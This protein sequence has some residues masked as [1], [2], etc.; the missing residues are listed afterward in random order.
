[1]IELY[2][3][4][5]CPVCGGHNWKD[6]L[7]CNAPPYEFAV[8]GIPRI[9]YVVCQCGLIFLDS[10]I[11]D[12]DEYY[13]ETYRKTLEENTSE[14][15]DKTLATEL[16]RA[17]RLTPEILKR[18]RSV[19][20]VLDVGSST[21]IF[22]SRLGEYFDCSLQGVEPSDA[23]RKHSVASGV[24][25][26]DKLNKVEGLFDLITC[27]HTLEHVIDPVEFLKNIVEKGNSETTFLIE[28]PFF[29]FRLCHP[30]L[31]T[32]WQLGMVLR[33]AGLMIVDIVDGKDITVFAR[34]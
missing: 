28:V 20:R 18:V 8:T 32:V 25:T 24:P 19:N 9:K 23:F 17:K 10:F 22:L 27:I 33:D 1:L 13:K 2:Q 31:Y 16:D 30:I 15:T 7:I 5:K 4:E 11:K 26:V 34:R 21:G 14:V 6:I 29:D 3:V 12:V